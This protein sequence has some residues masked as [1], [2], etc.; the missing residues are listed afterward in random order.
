M[1]RLIDPSF[2]TS[3]RRWLQKEHPKTT[4]VVEGFHISRFPVTNGEYVRFLEA[5][6]GP[7]PESIASG[8][9]DDHP[10]WG[11]DCSDA[12][13][14]C[15]WYGRN[16]HRPC[17]LPTEAEWEYAARGPSGRE[18]PFGDEFDPS[19]CNTIESGIGTTTPVDRYPHGASEWGVYDL[20]GNVEEWTADLYRPYP[21]GRFVD[22]DLSDAAGGTYRVLRGGSFARGG[23]LA[24][25]ARRHGP[26]PG[27]DYRYRGFRVVLPTAAGRGTLVDMVT[28]DARLRLLGNEIYR[29]TEILHGRGAGVRV[30]RRAAQAVPGGVGEGYADADRRTAPP[31]TRSRRHGRMGEG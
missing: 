8:E 14:F 15:G 19:R 21:G 7:P 28:R 10:V 26:Y 4:V 6:G 11:V 9:P 20:A 23:D 30:D 17:R 29:R 1:G 22:D 27:P 12:E 2:A 18:Y 25:C 3:F 13:R 5:A 16:A 24:R 31:G